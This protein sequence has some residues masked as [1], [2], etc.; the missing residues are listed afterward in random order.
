MQNWNIC[1][2][3]SYNANCGMLHRSKLQVYKQ[4]A[5]RLRNHWDPN[6]SIV[7][8]MAT[9][10]ATDLACVYSCDCDSKA[11]PSRFPKEE[12]PVLSCQSM[13]LILCLCRNLSWVITRIWICTQVLFCCLWINC[14]V[15]ALPY[16]CFDREQKITVESVN[17][18]GH[19]WKSQKLEKMEPCCL[20]QE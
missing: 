11:V 6:S 1:G 9:R 10:I 7:H 20:W 16:F 5:A 17:S 3:Y 18:K 14:S 13:A 19:L 4:Q 8:K 15:H 12:Q 2:V